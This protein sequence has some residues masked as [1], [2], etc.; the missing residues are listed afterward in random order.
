MPRA[1]LPA[2]TPKRKAWNKGHFIG[3]KRPLLPMQVW[4]IRARLTSTQTLPRRAWAGSASFRT[5]A[6]QASIKRPEEPR[7]T[8]RMTFWPISSQTPSGSG[9]LGFVENQ[10]LE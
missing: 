7:L 8:L 5:D 1:Q 9:T 6:D 3:Q 4:A 10:V 2:V